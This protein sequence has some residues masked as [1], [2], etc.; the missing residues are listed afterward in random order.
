MTLVRWAVVLFLQS[1]GCY[2]HLALQHFTAT[3][4]EA[5]A[6]IDTHITRLASR[7]VDDERRNPNSYLSPVMVKGEMW[8]I[9][10]AYLKGFCRLWVQVPSTHAMLQALADEHLWAWFAGL[11][12]AK[13][14]PLRHSCTYIGMHLLLAVAAEAKEA[15]LAA[16]L[17]RNVLADY[18]GA[19]PEDENVARHVVREQHKQGAN[20]HASGARGVAA[21]GGLK[22]GREALR[23]PTGEKQGDAKMEDAVWTPLQTMSFGD[24]VRAA[25][26]LKASGGRVAF[27][28]DAGDRYSRREQEREQDSKTAAGEVRSPPPDEPA[29]HS[30]GVRQQH[31]SV[32]SCSEAALERFRWLVHCWR[33]RKHGILRCARRGRDGNGAEVE[34]L[35]LHVFECA[36]RRC[37]VICHAD[38]VH[39]WR[40]RLLA[41]AAKAHGLSSGQRNAAFAVHIVGHEASVLCPGKTLA[42]S[43]EASSWEPTSCVTCVSSASRMGAG[44]GG[45][46][47]ERSTSDNPCRIG[48]QSW[49]SEEIGA[50]VDS[51]HVVIMSYEVAQRGDADRLGLDLIIVDQRS[52]T[53]ETGVGPR[54]TPVVDKSRGNACMGCTARASRGMDWSRVALLASQH[55]RCVPRIM[56]RPDLVADFDL[57]SFCNAILREPDLCA[58][59]ALGAQGAVSTQALVQV[60]GMQLKLLNFVQPFWFPHALLRTGDEERL[61]HC[62]PNDLIPAIRAFSA[63]LANSSLCSSTRI[64]DSTESRDDLAKHAAGALAT[65]T[66]GRSSLCVNCRGK[67][68]EVMEQVQRAE[69][70]LHCLK[71]MTDVLMTSVPG[72][73]QR[74]MLP[75]LRFK[76]CALFR[77]CRVCST[78]AAIH[79]R[80]THTHTHAY[81]HAHTHTHT[82]THAT[83]TS[84]IAVTIHT[85]SLRWWIRRSRLQVWRHRY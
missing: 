76:W 57:L 19:S 10:R 66:A 72:L 75:V 51:A 17:G 18:G 35:L 84:T 73:Q 36:G 30:G 46:G 2:R 21:A 28:E 63:V 47:A 26:Q 79:V 16:V 9:F 56:V 31:A 29:H 4:K 8:Q 33:E 71:K 62:S 83:P 12:V 69:E 82:H 11:G 50:G 14:L 3:T 49:N 54:Q 65:I 53:A 7:L 32:E 64:P 85:L 60:I 43:G 67:R 52:P 20:M 1:A 5:R 38:S 61:M 45:S 27:G 41:G 6:S 22:G 24:L 80:S 40:E 55:A 25:H 81:T 78:H 13:F 42:S 23:A 77:L 58:E 34:A 44:A 37:L 70:R 59:S 74:D 15:H 39:D 48:R 68:H